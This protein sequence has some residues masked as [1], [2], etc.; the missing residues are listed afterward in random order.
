MKGR[1]HEAKKGGRY[2]NSKNKE[3]LK[4]KRN[5]RERIIS[6]GIEVTTTVSPFRSLHLD[7][8]VRGRYTCRCPKSHS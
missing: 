8:D 5:G 3:K 7:G 1:I 2:D 4:M 6:N